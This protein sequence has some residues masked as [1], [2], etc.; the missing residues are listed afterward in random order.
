MSPEEEE[1]EQRGMINASPEQA[2]RHDAM[3]VAVAARCWPNMDQLQVAQGVSAM[4][5][6]MYSS[7][8]E[9]SMGTANMVHASLNPALAYQSM[10]HL[11]QMLALA[12]ENL[13]IATK[14]ADE[15]AHVVVGG[16]DV[17][18]DLDHMR[19]ELVK[20]TTDMVARHVNE[21][22]KAEV[23]EGFD[24][25]SKQLA[26]VLVE[27]IGMALAAV[28]MMDPVEIDTL[29]DVEEGQYNGYWPEEMAELWQPTEEV[30]KF[31]DEAVDDDGS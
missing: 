25:A 21:D 15:L 28:A 7:E 19:G 4:F 24:V 8:K 23:L 31:M 26:N 3:T 5:G 20:Q 11:T 22:H 30:V 16:M 18:E 9:R 13:V 6:Y 2:Q 10:R 27:R 17:P 29:L 14:V 12:I 1:F